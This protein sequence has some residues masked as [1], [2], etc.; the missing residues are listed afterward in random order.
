MYTSRWS[1]KFWPTPETGRRG[2]GKGLTGGLN[3]LLNI[4]LGLKSF[5]VGLCSGPVSAGS[6]GLSL[7]P[8]PE[9]QSLQPVPC[10]A[11]SPTAQ[12]P[13][14][15]HVGKAGWSK[16]KITNKNSV[17]SKVQR[18]LRLM[19]GVTVPH[20]VTFVPH[21]TPPQANKTH[22]ALSFCRSGLRGAVREVLTRQVAHHG[23]AQLLEVVCIPQ[24]REHEQLRRV[25]GAPTQDHFLAGVNLEKSRAL[26]CYIS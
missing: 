15:V 13:Y 20:S 12:A 10:P 22:C 1:C 2:E 8:L 17:S 4:P 21:P 5:P 23:N 6:L 7:M 25:D 16:A 24:T 26:V 19:E 14:P 3:W 18:T 9:K 11:P